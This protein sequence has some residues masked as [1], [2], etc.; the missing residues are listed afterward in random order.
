MSSVGVES[1]TV[2]AVVA[3]VSVVSSVGNFGLV[4]NWSFICLSSSDK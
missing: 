3:V 1:M 4:N 2:M